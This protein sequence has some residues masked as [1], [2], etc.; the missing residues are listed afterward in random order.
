MAGPLH[1]GLQ[2]YLGKGREG[3]ASSYDGR[4]LRPPDWG[5]SYEVGIPLKREADRPPEVMQGPVLER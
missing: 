1:R 4:I 3:S 2:F 5:S